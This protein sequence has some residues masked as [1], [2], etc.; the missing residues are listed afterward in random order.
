VESLNLRGLVLIFAPSVSLLSNGSIATR[1]IGALGMDG[2]SIGLLAV[3]LGS[4]SRSIEGV[5]GRFAGAGGGSNFMAGGIA[6]MGEGS[7]ID[8]FEAGRLSSAPLMASSILPVIS[9]MGFLA[10]GGAGAIVGIAL[11]QLWYDLDRGSL[12]LMQA[13]VQRHLLPA[14]WDPGIIALLQWPTWVVFLIPALILLLLGRRR[15]SRRSFS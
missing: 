6:A 1:A 4:S 10:G 14:I 13:V 12:N 7:T 15:P 9:S 3:A 2:T 8:F 11:G 5:A